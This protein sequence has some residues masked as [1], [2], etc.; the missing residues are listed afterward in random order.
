MNGTKI[1][2]TAVAVALTAMLI[3]PAAQADENQHLNQVATSTATNGKLTRNQALALGNTAC[4]AVRSAVANGMTLGPGA[5]PGRPGGR[6]HLTEHGAI[7]RGGRW[8]VSSRRRGRSTL[9]TA[10]RL[11]GSFNMRCG[12]PSMQ[13]VHLASA[14]QRWHAAMAN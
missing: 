2:L 13:L 14:G 10:Y 11:D 8:N 3:A 1:F 7:S 4:Q 5:C 9:L 12:S 6:L